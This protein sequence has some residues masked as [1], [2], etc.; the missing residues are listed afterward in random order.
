MDF[1]QRSTQPEVI[2]FPGALDAAQTLQMLTE[3]RTIN[4]VLGMTRGYV[5]MLRR[6]LLEEEV[7]QGSGSLSLLD[8]GSGAS[9]LPQALLASLRGTVPLRVTALDFNF[10]V[11]RAARDWSRGEERLSIIQ[12]D[13]LALPVKPES[14]DVVVCC[15][16]LHHF[17][18]EQIARILREAA[19][20][21]RRAVV[22]FD[23][24]RHPLAY[25]GIRVLTRLFSRSHAIRSDGPCSVLKGFQREEM[26]RLV[27]QAGLPAP[28]IRWHWPFRFSLVIRKNGASTFRP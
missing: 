7:R 25:A 20:A 26:R 15:T 17:P 3:L 16:V 27:R 13:I 9:D 8:L 5:R 19:R 28:L 23:L 14:V 10:L 21:A 11:C 4:R 18:E 2:D 22:V 1:S 12:G 6:L 24:Q